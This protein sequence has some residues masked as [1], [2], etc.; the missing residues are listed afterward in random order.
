MSDEMK[1]LMQDLRAVLK[2]HNASIG[3][4]GCCGSPWMILGDPCDNASESV[5][6]FDSVMEQ[7]AKEEG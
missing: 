7:I 6:D 3:G 4:C 1:A 2:R 5:D